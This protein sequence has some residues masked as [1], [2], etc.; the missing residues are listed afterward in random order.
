VPESRREAYLPTLLLLAPEWHKIGVGV[1]KDV[2]P[3]CKQL[4]RCLCVAIDRQVLSF[5]ERRRFPQVRR[6][7]S[8]C[9]RGNKEIEKRKRTGKY[10]RGYLVKTDGRGGG[11]NLESLR[12]TPER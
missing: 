9:G 10:N 4:A 3:L 12:R 8:F 11:R 1:A 5:A 6:I 2:K 7:T